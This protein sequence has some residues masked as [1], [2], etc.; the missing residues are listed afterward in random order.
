MVLWDDE[1]RTCAEIA[2]FSRKDAER[3]PDY[4][5]FLHEAGAFVRELIWKTPRRRSSAEREGHAGARLKLR[6]WAAVPSGSST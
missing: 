4:N 5:R 1:R 3:Y 6:A 2:K